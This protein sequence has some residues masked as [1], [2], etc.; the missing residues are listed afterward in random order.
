MAE[1]KGFPGWYWR[2]CVRCAVV[3]V[4]VCEWPV[5]KWRGDTD[6]MDVLKQVSRDVFRAGYTGLEGESA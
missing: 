6:S 2:F 5:Y 1:T 3:T 4:F